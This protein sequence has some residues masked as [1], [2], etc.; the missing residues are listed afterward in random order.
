MHDDEFRVGPR[1]SGCRV[2][3]EVGVA[4]EP[5]EGCVEHDRCPHWQGLAAG[6]NPRP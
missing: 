5:A 2:D 4:E 3:E 1:E 6:V